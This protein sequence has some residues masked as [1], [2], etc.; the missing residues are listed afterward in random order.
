RA[1]RSLPAEDRATVRRPRPHHGDAREQEDRRADG[2]APLDLQPGHRAHE[3]DQAAAARLTPP[4]GSAPR[5]RLLTG[6]TAR[7]PPESTVHQQPCAQPRA[8]RGC[9]VSA[10]PQHFPHARPWNHAVLPHSSPAMWTRAV[11]KLGRALA[12]SVQAW[13]RACGRVWMTAL[14]LW[15]T[16]PRSVD[17]LWVENR[18]PQGPLVTAQ[19]DPQLLHRKKWLLTCEKTRYPQFPQ[20]LL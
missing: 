15:A 12:S 7:I 17:G 20:H 2:R 9:C 13:G 19:L 16:T 8:A 3:P 14:F 11:Q 18:S 1:D 6:Q 5:Q 10:P 4:R